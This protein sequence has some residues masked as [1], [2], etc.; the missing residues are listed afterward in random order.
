MSRWHNYFRLDFRETEFNGGIHFDGKAVQGV[1]PIVPFHRGF[2]APFEEVGIALKGPGIY[3][4]A[5]L[6]NHDVYR[7]Y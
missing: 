4:I 2:L 6:R 1:G 7:Y 5:S 3:Y